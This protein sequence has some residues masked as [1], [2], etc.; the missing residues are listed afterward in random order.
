MGIIGIKR[1][2]MGPG[3]NYVIVYPKLRRRVIVNIDFLFR[4]PGNLFVNRVWYPVRLIEKSN[5]P[6]PRPGRLFVFKRGKDKFRPVGEIGFSFGN[7][8][9]FHIRI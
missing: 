6:F 1:I 2:H 8:P 4:S 5:I 9:P 3:Y 7:I